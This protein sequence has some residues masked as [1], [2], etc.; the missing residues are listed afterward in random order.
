MYL[1]LCQRSLHRIGGGTP[2]WRSLVIHHVPAAQIVDGRGAMKLD[3]AL[4]NMPILLTN[5]EY[6]KIGR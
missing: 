5:N 3:R 2:P 4:P 1:L 6:A